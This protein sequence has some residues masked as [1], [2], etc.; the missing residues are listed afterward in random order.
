MNINILL[1]KKIY[2]I[3]IFFFYLTSFSQNI[4]FNSFP[5]DNQLFKRDANLNTSNILIDGYV[6]QV[7]N[8]T[9]LTLEVFRGGVAFNTS[10][11][12]LAFNTDGIA[13]FNF[14]TVINSELINYDFK[15]VSNTG[16]ILK[17][18]VNIVSGD[19][20]IVQGQ[21][22]ADNIGTGVVDCT[23][24]FM[25][26][27]KDG[28]WSSSNLNSGGIGCGLAKKITQ[29]K[30]IPVV[31]FNGAKGGQNINY[32]QSNQLNHFDISTNYGQLLSDYSDAGFSSG[33]TNAFI[34]YQGEADY[35]NSISY[36][37]NMFYQLFDDWVL[38]YNPNKF[39]LFQVKGC[40]AQYHNSI[41]EAQRQ[42]ALHLN[43]IL[44]IVS[45]NGVEQLSTDNCHYTYSNY[46]LLGFRV[47][48]IINH[49]IYNNINTANI[50]SPYPINIRYSNSLKNEIKF[51]VYPISDNFTVE[52]GVENY[53]YFEYNSLVSNVSISNNNTVTLTLSQN[54]T[55][56]NLKLSFIGPTMAS[57]IIKNQKGIGLLSFKDI[58]I[59]DYIDTNFS[60]IEDGSWSY[61]YKNS[62][63]IN[64]IFAIEHLPI[65]SGANTNTFVLDAL[66]VSDLANEL[67][68]TELKTKQ[69]TFN[70]SKYW[71]LKINILTNGWV[72]MRFFY[73]NSLETELINSVN[74]FVSLSNSDYTSDL[75]YI[76]TNEI[77]DPVNQISSLGYSVAIKK[78]GDTFN[79]GNYSGNSYL[80]M[81]KVNL[82]SYYSGGTVI[83]RVESDLIIPTGTIRF[84]NKNK[85]FQG[86]NGTT[87]LDFN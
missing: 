85:K 51:E 74:N 43:N 27:Y 65:G 81:N 86:W 79:Y 26:T 2:I 9:S 25:R 32:F 48:N 13:N 47:Y 29:E 78:A 60:K 12:N 71:N 69:G 76:K 67:S 83:K 3:I 73:P 56:D 61:Y 14:V 59:N 72:N 68:N 40:G 10:S 63:L 36:Y 8:Y 19:V 18:S 87:W 57:P 34:W 80:Q 42:I 53:F 55:D 45:T 41:Y 31:I 54:I 24:D 16:V 46:E 28:V 62:D 50:F 1:R 49:Q 37:Q 44:T 20:Y 38:D 75:M 64:P 15:I 39:Y 22:N 84:N 17:Q 5:E 11:V 33:D 77:F 6:L 70:M 4:V 23:N 7:S 35:G 21:S 82:E 30:N 66:E 52:N 58:R